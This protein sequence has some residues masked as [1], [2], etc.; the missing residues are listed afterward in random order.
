MVPVLSGTSFKVHPESLRRKAIVYV[1]QSTMTQV[2]EHKES[3]RLQYALSDRAVGLGWPSALVHV[4]D[5][6]LGFSGAESTHRHGF[7]RLV[8]MVGLGEVGIV[9]GREVSRLARNNQDWYH[10]LDLCAVFGTLIGDNDGIYDPRLFNDRL[11]LGLKGTMSEA[12]LHII[13]GRLTAGLENKARR[14]ELYLGLPVGFRLTE[15]GKVEKTP[16]E[17]VQATIQQ[18]FEKFRRLGSPYAVLVELLEEGGQLPQRKD[19]FGQ[20]GVA[21]CRPTY[22]AVHRFLTHPIY[23]GAY[24]FGRTGTR[25]TVTAEG[26]LEKHRGHWEERSRWPVLLVDHH[27]EYISWVEHEE[28]LRRIHANRR[29]WGQPGPIQRGS[30][31]LSGLVRCGICQ[32]SMLVT[33]TGANQNC[34]R[35]QCNRPDNYAAREKCQSFGA[36]RFEK[37]VTTQLLTVLE[38]ESLEAALLALDDY[39][40]QRKDQERLLD[41]EVQK[42]RQAEDRAHRQFQRVEPENRLVARELERQWESALTTMKEAERARDLRRSQIPPPLTEEEK[43]EL[44]KELCRLPQLWEASTT[45]PQAKKELARLLIRH[46]E[47]KMDGEARELRFAIHWVTGQVTPGKVKLPR[48]GEHRWFTPDTDI[49]I[50]RRLSPDHTDWEISKA[51]NTAGRRTSHGSLWSVARVQSVRFS[52]SIEKGSGRIPGMLK[53]KEVRARLRI[54]YAEFRRLVGCGKLHAEHPYPHAR[55]R[56]PEKEVEQLVRE[57]EKQKVRRGASQLS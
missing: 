14:G 5:E 8:S 41:L 38:P 1:R 30:S 10:L 7:Q 18:V 3:Q 2:E 25:V 6:D 53:W 23:A 56:V 52:H 32:R 46:I 21:W 31:L 4:I 42:A 27:P 11:L 34:P 45:T 40:K 35:F 33:Y 47:A 24:V 49:E 39:E 16:D 48:T 9:L 54:Q 36:G 13:R 15:D 43:T 19:A 44:R 17:L 12:E 37:S 50:I 20:S 28:N 57:K 22:P 29:G 51:L 55:W 26:R